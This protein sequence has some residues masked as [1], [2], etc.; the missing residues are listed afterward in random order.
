MGVSLH[1][2]GGHTAMQMVYL[3]VANGQTWQVQARGFTWHFAT[4]EEASDFALAMAEEFA[5]ASGRTTYVRLQ[6]DTGV[7]EELQVY[8]GVPLLPAATTPAATARRAP[9]NG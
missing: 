1:P 8:C 9:G 2:S 7:I 5:I 3:I 4:R 6:H